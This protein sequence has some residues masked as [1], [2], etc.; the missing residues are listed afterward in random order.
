MRRLSGIVRREFAVSAVTAAN[1]ET[2]TYCFVMLHTTA[3]FG[4]V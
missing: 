4:V 3:D 2:S 1:V